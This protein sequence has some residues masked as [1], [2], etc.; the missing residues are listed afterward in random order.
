[1][2]EAGGRRQLCWRQKAKVN[3]LPLLPQLPLPPLLSL[4]SPVTCHL[5]SLKPAKVVTNTN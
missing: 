5:P 1:M 4:L 3:I 2:L